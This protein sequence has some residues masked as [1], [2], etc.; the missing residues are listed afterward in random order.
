[1]A[2]RDLLNQQAGNPRRGQRYRDVVRNGQE[3]H[4]YASG[5]DQVVGPA[6]AQA[7]TVGQVAHVPAAAAQSQ[8]APIGDL[9]AGNLADLI[10]GQ[11]A[12]EAKGGQG[13]PVLGS[14]MHDGTAQGA[15]IGHNAEGQL[16][17][18]VQVG[19]RKFH[20]YLSPSGDRVVREI[21]RPPTFT[22]TPAS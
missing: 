10:A 14:H 19:D 17:S 21:K 3:V 2:L 20:V 22:P 13:G 16:Y 6:G 1:M 4:D 15:S 18:Q 9:P 5:P 7:S 8:A 12:Y 11:R